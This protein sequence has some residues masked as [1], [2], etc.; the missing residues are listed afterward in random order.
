MKHFVLHLLA[1][2]ALGALALAGRAA[3][4]LRVVCTIPDLADIARTIG[5]DR[6]DVTSICK[7]TENTHAVVTKPSHLV[8]VSR[9][10]VF[11]E[12]GLSLETAFVPGLLEGARNE[13]IRPGSPG[14]VN[15]SVDFDAIEVP[16]ALS[17]R[18]GDVHPQGN[19]HINLDPRFGRHAAAK[20]LAGLVAVDPGSKAAYEARA[21]EYG[22]QL[23]AAEA[24]WKSAEKAFAGRKIVVYHKEFAY[25]AAAAGIATVG[26]IE[27][28][29]GI[30]PTP[31][32]LAELVGAMKRE[33]GLVIVTAPWSNGREVEQVAKE[34]GARVVEIPNLVG[35]GSAKT[36]IELMDLAHQRLAQGFGVAPPR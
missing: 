9:A 17:R 25:L 29:P 27:P 28:K 36:W 13:R 1:I 12:V 11:V 33:S 10:D 21:A 19:P 26:S 2:A 3:D 34:S 18:D 16:T 6:V 31:N 15:V 20:I 24:R 4:P 30:P 5:G 35:G 22:K 23:D 7:G 14:F 32:H 8:A